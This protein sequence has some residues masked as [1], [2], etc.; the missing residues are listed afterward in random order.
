MSQHHVQK[1]VLSE[2]QIG[3]THLDVAHAEVSYNVS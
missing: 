3:L 2:V 1:H